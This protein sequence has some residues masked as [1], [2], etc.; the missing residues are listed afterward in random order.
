[1]FKHEYTFIETDERI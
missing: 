1:L